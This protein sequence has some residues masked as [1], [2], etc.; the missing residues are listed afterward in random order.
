MLHTKIWTK[1]FFVIALVAITKN[2]QSQPNWNFDP[3]LY[4]YT[5]TLTG[6]AVIECMESIDEND[7][8]AAFIGGELRG[9]QRFD[10]VLN[11][12][13]YAYMVIYDSVFT[14]NSVSFKLYDASRNKIIDVAQTF[15]FTEN[16]NVGNDEHPFVF[17]STAEPLQVHLSTSD[18]YKFANPGDTI[19]QL[20]VNNSLQD[21]LDASYH[22]INDTLGIDN[23]YF[24]IQNNYL[25]LNEVLN[26]LSQTE[27][28]IHLGL[29]TISGCIKDSSFVLNLS[30]LVAVDPSGA[31]KAVHVYPNPA[32]DFIYLSQ[33][34]DHSNLLLYD[35][36][37]NSYTKLEMDL[38]NRIA[39]GHLSSQIYY[40]LIQ[41]ANAHKWIR[42]SVIR[43]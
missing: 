27:L 16:S 15:I 2:S 20:W 19:C 25:V 30:E 29:E 32:A 21:T 13:N 4:E 39:V 43:N 17:E 35:P 41:T 12:R 38:G 23:H 34:P 22:F 26:Q 7:L 9:V 28:H 11:N 8:V 1:L 24:K 33:I 36:L 18:V 14:G 40:L 42:F 10:G 6:V 3:A 5:M 37:R 31:L